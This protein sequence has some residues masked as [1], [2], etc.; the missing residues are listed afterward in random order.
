MDR[1]LTLLVALGLA[2]SGCHRKTHHETTAELTRVSAVARDDAGKPVAVDVEVSYR[3]CPGTQ[4]EVVRGGPDFAACIGKHRV[5][6]ALGVAIDHEWSSEGF[7]TWKI[8][9]I[10]DCERTVDPDDQASYAMVRECSDWVVNGRSI[11]FQCRYTPEDKLIA[12]CPWFRR[13]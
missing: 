4:T 6:E 13:R 11:G 2:A 8:R 1:R 9:R 7:Y 10:G 3:E 5:G 12:A